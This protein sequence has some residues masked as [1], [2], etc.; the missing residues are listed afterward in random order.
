MG[1]FESRESTWD[2]ILEYPSQK[3]ALIVL[4]N[5]FVLQG[6]CYEILLLKPWRLRKQSSQRQ[7]AKKELRKDVDTGHLLGREAPLELGPESSAVEMHQDF[8]E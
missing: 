2:M 4:G 5:N 1:L 3:C 8:V 6:P 7:K